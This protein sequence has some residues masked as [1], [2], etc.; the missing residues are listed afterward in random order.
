MNKTKEFCQGCE[1][2]DECLLRDS[3]LIGRALRDEGMEQL[4]KAE[5]LGVSHAQVV[6]QKVNL[7]QSYLELKNKIIKEAYEVGCLEE[8]NS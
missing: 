5:K 7:Q 6:I 2:V 3:F 4:D 8:F 1:E